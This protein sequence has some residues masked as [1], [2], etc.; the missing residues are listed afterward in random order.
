MTTENTP[1]PGSSYAAPER[2]A[3]CHL[4]MREIHDG[5]PGS[6]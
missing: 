2:F 4:G 6:F 3:V 5:R 1:A